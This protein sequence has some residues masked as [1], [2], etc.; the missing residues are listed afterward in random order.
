MIALDL[1]GVL[2]GAAAVPAVRSA[3]PAARRRSWWGEPGVWFG[4]VVAAFI[5]NEVLFN[6]YMLDVHGGD[7]SFI[8]R[9]LPP[10]YFDLAD[11]GP[12]RW[13]ARTTPHAELLAPTLLRV[14]AFLELPLGLL[15]YLIVARWF[16][17]RLYRRL[18]AP[19]TWWCAATAYS[20][21]FMLI[22]VELWNP[23]TRDDLVI[24]GVS[25]VVTGLALGGVLRRL[26]GRIDPEVTGVTSLALFVVSTVAFGGLILALYDTLLLY[27]LGRVARDAPVAVACGLVLVAARLGT[28]RLGAARLSAGGSSGPYLRLLTDALRTWLAVFFVAALPIRYM[29]NF[30]SRWLALALGLATVVVA[31][32]G[33]VRAT[34]VSR[35]DMAIVLP[36][37]AVLG[38]TVGAAGLALPARY[39]EARLLVIAVLFVA[40]ATAVLVGA[41]RTRAHLTSASGSS[42]ARRED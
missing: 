30:G 28:A 9:Y 26:D 21:A 31:V 17:A 35:R 19:V 11:N 6:V 10:G 1:L 39:S 32:A 7:S 27:N 8:A 23:Y 41:D 29:L 14:Q 25:F 36:L 2:A 42:S 16:D 20:A 5:V 38:A 12:I 34:A 13:L 4:L 37:A 33:A 3:E 22:E 18:L 40:S 24:R 15:A